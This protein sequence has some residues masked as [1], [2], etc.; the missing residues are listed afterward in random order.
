ML[1][2]EL[3]DVG[4]E[5]IFFGPMTDREKLK[6]K[7]MRRKTKV[8]KP[9]FRV[10]CDEE[11]EEEHGREGIGEEPA[12]ELQ[13]AQESADIEAI[14]VRDV[15]EDRLGDCGSDISDMSPSS[16]SSQST[17]SSSGN[18]EIKAGDLEDDSNPDTGLSTWH[19]PSPTQKRLR[20]SES[21]INVNTP[22][23]SLVTVSPQADAA[24]VSK[25]YGSC[26]IELFNATDSVTGCD[27]TCVETGI[28]GSSGDE[29]KTICS[30]SQSEETIVGRCD[31]TV[32]VDQVHGA[33]KSPKGDLGEV[34]MMVETDVICSSANVKMDAAPKHH[35]ISKAQSQTLSS[36]E[37]E[38]PAVAKPTP[39]TTTGHCGQSTVIYSSPLLISTTVQ[40]VQMQQPICYGNNSSL[41]PVP[42]C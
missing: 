37:T 41:I 21:A 31:D 42:C 27:A 23:F 28:D 14:E 1:L 4:E 30:T 6:S 34:G 12:G 40:R 8:F 33:D 5:E 29:N 20:G 24:A 2:N 35:Q 38:P 10:D 32:A 36:T 17:C 18:T 7:K 26:G 39:S 22:P 15:R 13:G 9:G 16:V 19:T 3:D 25:D 11:E